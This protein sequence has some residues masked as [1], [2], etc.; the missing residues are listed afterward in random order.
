MEIADIVTPEIIT[1]TEA[2][3]RLEV[4]NGRFIQNMSVNRNYLEQVKLTSAGQNPFAAIL[5]CIDS[6]APAEII[7]D[8]G[9]GDIFNVRI[10]GNILNDDIIGSLEFATQIAGAKLIVVLGHTSCGAVKGA[11]DNAKLGHLT[12]LVKKLEPAVNEVHNHHHNNIS[13]SEKVNLV[14]EKNVELVSK[15]LLKRSH[16][17]KGLFETEDINIIGAIYDVE[18]GK[19]RFKDR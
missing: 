12:G 3:N 16:V 4:G 10:A 8:Q 2:L 19:V 11:L 9:I 14:A 15:E 5:G 1:P 17:L 6:R 18:T 13:A 7:F